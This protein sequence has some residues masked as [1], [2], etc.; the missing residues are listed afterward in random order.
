[1]PKMRTNKA[2]KSRFR[3]TGTGKL[4]RGRPNRRHIMTK[5]TPKRKRQLRRPALVSDAQEKTYKR[6]M[7]VG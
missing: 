5:K 1:M 7:A 3:L 4:K 2:V 6:M